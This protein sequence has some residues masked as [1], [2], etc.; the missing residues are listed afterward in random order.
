[1]VTR[2]VS[3]SKEGIFDVDDVDDVDKRLR[4]GR[5]LG[6]GRLGVVNQT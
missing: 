6:V 2:R 5:A 3:K 1:M 4:R